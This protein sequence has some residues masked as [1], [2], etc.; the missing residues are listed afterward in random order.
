[1][2]LAMPLQSEKYG[3]AGGPRSKMA[4]VERIFEC[5][6]TPWMEV[7]PEASTPSGANIL[8]EPSSSSR[9]SRRSIDLPRRVQCRRRDAS[10]LR[11]VVGRQR[12]RVEQ[13][14]WVDRGGFPGDRRID[15]CRR[16]HERRRRLRRN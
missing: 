1:M 4:R 2:S 8:N 16:G 6:D 11:I 7:A 15:G 5:L 13:L 10:S 14:D 12:D 3:N 9:L